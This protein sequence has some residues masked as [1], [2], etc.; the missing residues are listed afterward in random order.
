MRARTTYLE[1]SANSYHVKP[2]GWIR[3]LRENKDK[4]GERLGP[5]D[6]PT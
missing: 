5:W 6:L 1:S 3:S 4:V 2:L